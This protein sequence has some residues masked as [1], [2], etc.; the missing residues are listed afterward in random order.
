MAQCSGHSH[1]DSRILL[2]TILAQCVWSVC[3][4]VFDV[5]APN[6]E[7]VANQSRISPSWRNSW[8]HA[9][10]LVRRPR[11]TLTTFR[12]IVRTLANATSAQVRIGEQRFLAMPA[13]PRLTLSP[14]A[15]HALHESVHFWGQN[16][17]GIME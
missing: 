9:P 17:H 3:C 11:Q 10:L 8:S 4:F 14:T 5:L 16:D 6:Q 7:V 2:G 12:T 1:T 13:N 15:L